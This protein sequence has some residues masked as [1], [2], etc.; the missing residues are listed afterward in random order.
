M[1]MVKKVSGYLYQKLKKLNYG[2]VACE[3][4]LIYHCNEYIYTFYHWRPIWLSSVAEAG[5]GIHFGRKE[6]PPIP[7][8]F[9]TSELVYES[10]W[11]LAA[12]ITVCQIYWSLLDFVGL[13]LCVCF[14]K[15]SWINSEH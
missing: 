7:Y 5:K 6:I 8:N 9:L 11:Q 1:K 2:V 12:N 14:L 10:M 4:I 15:L 3:S 13:C